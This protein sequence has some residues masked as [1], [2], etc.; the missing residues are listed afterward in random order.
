MILRNKLNI[1]VT[2]LLVSLAFAN[3]SNGSGVNIGHERSGVAAGQE[4]SSLIHRIASRPKKRPHILKGPARITDGD[5]LVIG[6][7]HVR[8]NGLAAPE[9]NEPGGYKS[10]LKL[11]KIT[12]R[13]SVECR[14]SGVRSY[15]REVGICYVAGKDVAIEMVSSGNGRDC[16]RYSKGRYLGC[17]LNTAST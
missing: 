13:K 14:L 9:L 6:S 15:K 8:L 2:L 4:T 16:P 1:V 7:T 3:K 17:G 10:R 11:I 5:T 12:Q